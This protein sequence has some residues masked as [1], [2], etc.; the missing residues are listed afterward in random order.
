VL[1]TQPTDLHH[2]LNRVNQPSDCSIQEEQ[3]CPQQRRVS[4]CALQRVL[5]HLPSFLATGSDADTLSLCRRNVNGVSSAQ[6]YV[7]TPGVW[8]GRSDV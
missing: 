7:K 2:R 3:H 5:V 6:I 4:Q 8:T 1:C